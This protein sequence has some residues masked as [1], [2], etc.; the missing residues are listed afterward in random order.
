MHL[1]DSWPLLSR[2]Q[3]FPYF[4]EAIIVGRKPNDPKGND[5]RK[6]AEQQIDG[7]TL[8]GNGE[9]QAGRTHVPSRSIIPLL[10]VS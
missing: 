6:T 4:F 9:T 1:A 10:D 8:V 7:P 3:R 5:A 2:S